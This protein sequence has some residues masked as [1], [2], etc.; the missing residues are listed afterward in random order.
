MPHGVPAIP[1]AEDSKDL[2]GG[3]TIRV[4]GLPSLMPEKVTVF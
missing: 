4:E 1:S 3:A 2:A